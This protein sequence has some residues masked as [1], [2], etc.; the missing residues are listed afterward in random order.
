M[1]QEQGQDFRF[2]DPVQ[3]S[4][5]MTVIAERSQKIVSEWLERQATQ[6]GNH[7]TLD[8]LNIGGAFF[9][10]TT[11]M[12]ADPAKLVQAQMSLWQDYMRLWQSTAQRMF[13]GASDSVAEPEFGDRRF[14]DPA[15]DEIQLFDFIKQ[16]YLLSARWLQSTV[17]E[18][19]GLDE[20]TAQKVD[21][22]TRQFV[23]AMAPSNFLMTNPQVLRTTLESGGENLVKG[24]ENLL[25]DLEQGKGRLKIKM[26]D[27]EAFEV[28]HNIAVTPGKVVYQNDL[29]QL[30]QYQPT[31]KTVHKR[32][33]LVI[34]PWINKFYILDLR[35]K[36]SFIKWLVDQGQ[37]VFVISWVNPDERLA[38]KTFDDY[39]LEGAVGGARRD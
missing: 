29:I 30:I 12:M 24:L 31:T 16:S 5:S 36:N 18:V 4:K 20:K 33:L 19:E 35:P 6:N 10:M 32:P 22:Y 2:P 7:G 17:N 38:Q 3:L 34:P 1:S 37:T 11:R 13:V 27:S 25:E 9:E 39:M 28:G 15:W 23:D 8:P 14:A 21:F 26:T